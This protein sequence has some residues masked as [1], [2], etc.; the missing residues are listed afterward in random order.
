MRVYIVVEYVVYELMGIH[1]V[2]TDEDKAKALRD[3]L[4]KDSEYSKFKIQSWDV[5]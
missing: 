4:Q 1:G 3:E 2:F 5:E